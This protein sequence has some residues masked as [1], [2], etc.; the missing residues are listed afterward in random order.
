MEDAQPRACMAAPQRA[1]EQPTCHAYSACCAHERPPQC[2]PLPRA[3]P[4]QTRAR[5]RAHLCGLHSRCVQGPCAALG[6]PRRARVIQLAAD[7]PQVAPGE[8]VQ[9]RLPPVPAVYLRAH[10]VCERAPE[11][12]LRSPRRYYPP[13]HAGMRRQLCS[14]RVDSCAC[15]N[16]R[17]P[18]LH[19]RTRAGSE[20]QKHPDG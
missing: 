2:V 3:V 11:G 6:C 13:K 20:R 17:V 4:A 1:I 15:R 10:G 7:A 19:A 8:H 5:G 14:A 18:L 12:V 16:L 9:E